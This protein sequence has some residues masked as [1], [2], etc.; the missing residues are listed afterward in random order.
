MLTCGLKSLSLA[1]QCSSIRP[2]PS[3]G[4]NYWIM[5]MI[6]VATFALYLEWLFSSTCI[7]NACQGTRHDNTQLYE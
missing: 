6:T 7:L 5:T 1:H 3:L 2:I 4:S